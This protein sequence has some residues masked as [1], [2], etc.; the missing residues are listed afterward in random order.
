VK[1]AG[2]R[3]LTDSVEMGWGNGGEGKSDREQ[4]KNNEG[5]SQC[6][7]RQNGKKK[8]ERGEGVSKRSGAKHIR[9]PGGGGSFRHENY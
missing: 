6:S 5:K 8:K 4:G 1:S 7:S 3:D 9:G 2:N